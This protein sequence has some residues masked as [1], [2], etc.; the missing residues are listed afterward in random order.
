MT[1][2]TKAEII[3]RAKELWHMQEARSGNPAF[4][5]EPELCELREE[6]LLAVAQSELMYSPARKYELER[7]EEYH[8][9][10]EK[11]GE[12]ESNIE[13]EIPFS[14]SDALASGFYL[15]GT[16][17]LSGK[18]NLCKILVSK[19]LNYGVT[20]YVV[21]P[22]LAW[23]LNSPINN[24]IQ[25]PKGNGCLTMEMRSTVFDVS[26]LGYAERFAFVKSFCKTL[27]DMHLS[28]NTQPEMLIFEE[29]QTYLPNGCMRSRKYSDI[30]DFV[31]VGGNYGLSFA[32][33]TQFSASVDKAIVKLA[34]QRYFGLTTED[35]DKRYVKS[36]IGKQWLNGLIQLQ[37]GQFL[38]QNRA[39]ISKFQCD[40]FGTAK[41]VGDGD[42]FNYEM[43][44][45]L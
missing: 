39:E 20:V 27:T 45:A 15:C 35:N 7:W 32:A 31:T 33:I 25:I 2:P 19:L 43:V 30:T 21:D 10:T 37:R 41:S 24:V 12:T 16:R 29:A 18:T 5:I 28:S 42:G 40:K 36:F 8:R 14:V 3:A 22:S 23:L 4:D 17:Q 34:Q 11:L 13:T 44:Y 26:R 38:Y 9:S 1:T 6:G